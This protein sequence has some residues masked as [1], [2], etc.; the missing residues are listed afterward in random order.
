MVGAVRL[1]TFLVPVDT[2][3]GPST[4]RATGVVVGD[5]VVDLT[6]PALGLPS[7]M[8]DLLGAGDDAMTAAA[9]AHTS[10]ARRFGLDQVQLAAPVPLPP[11]ILAIGMNY[12][13]H[14]KE[15]GRELPARQYWFNKQ[16]TCVAAPEEPIVIPSVSEQLDYEG[17]LAVVIGRRAKSVPAARWL[18]V[19]AGFTVVNDV[20]VRDWQ[21][22]SPT[23][24]MGKSFDTHC[25]MGPW[26]VTPDEVG[27]PRALSL[28]TWVNGELRQDASTEDLVF[29]PPEMVEYL[30]TVFPL[31]P[32]DVLATGTPSGVGAGYS[33][34]KWLREGD[35]VR[36]EIERVGSLQNPVVREPRRAPAPEPVVERPA[37]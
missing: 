21:A 22:H 14:V 27:D 36:I 16:R 18:E 35:V 25:P 26:I 5:E 19:V 2:P 33:P 20:S 7:D 31:E 13:E 30:T 1:V 11:K 12:R 37:P 8:A 24:T 10:V 4:R 29:S 3:S 28:R 32:G 9:R 15:M 17:E 6:D 34:P 23:F